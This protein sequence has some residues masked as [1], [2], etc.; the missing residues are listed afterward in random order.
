MKK[1]IKLILFFL[2]ILFLSDCS[3]TKYVSSSDLNPNLSKSFNTLSID[4]CNKIINF[5]SLTNNR[6]N[7]FGVMDKKPQVVI[8][9]LPLTPIFTVNKTRTL[10]HKRF[11]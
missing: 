8:N 5:Y 7:V 4:D 9:A 3:S 10:H 6:K 11:N 2:I 1:I